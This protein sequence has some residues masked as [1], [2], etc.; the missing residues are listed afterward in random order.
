MDFYYGRM[1]GNSARAAFGLAEAGATYQPHLLDTQKGENQSPAYLAINPMGK[2]PALVDGEFKLWE[3]NAINL[4]VAEKFPSARL[5]P[6]SL[7]SRTSVHRW[8]FFQAAHISPACIAVFRGTN[9][10]VQAFWKSKADPRA[11]E[12]GHKELARYLPVL[13]GAL[14]GRDW[15]ET[16]FSLA[17]IAYAPHLLMVDEGGFDFSQYPSVRAWLDRLQARPAWRRVAEMIFPS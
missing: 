17:D 6:P 10:R 11:L 5:V 12:H 7:P 13:E 15:L 4:Y 16:D 2:I 3:S 1:S 8:L 14:Q 9:P